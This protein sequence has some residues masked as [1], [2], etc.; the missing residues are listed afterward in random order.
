MLTPKDYE[1]AFLV[2]SGCNASGI[3]RSLDIM[4]AKLWEEAHHREKGTDWINGHPLV[5]LYLAQLCHLNHVG[6]ASVMKY[7][8]AYIDCERGMRGEELKYNE[9]PQG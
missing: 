8:E 7:Q 6:W 4:M 1:D 2:Q 5:T 3:V 9:T